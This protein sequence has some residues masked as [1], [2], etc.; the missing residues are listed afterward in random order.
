M[1]RKTYIRLLIALL[2]MSVQMISAKVTG[3]DKAVEPITW[4]TY[5]N[6]YYGF[7]VRVPST[8]L[9]QGENLFQDAQQFVYKDGLAVMEVSGG[10]NDGILLNQGIEQSFYAEMEKAKRDKGFIRQS[11]VLNTHYV[12]FYNRGDS[13]YYVSCRWNDNMQVRISLRYPT[14][15]DKK[16]HHFVEP[17]VYQR[18]NV[19]TEEQRLLASKVAT[20][21]IDAPDTSYDDSNTELAGDLAANATLPTGNADTS[22]N[23]D[24]STTVPSGYAAGDKT[25]VHQSQPQTVEIPTY[26]G[27]DVITVVYPDGTTMPDNPTVPGGLPTGDNSYTPTD[28]TGGNVSSLPS[29]DEYAPVNLPHIAMSDNQD[30]AISP[31][32]LETIANSPSPFDNIG[33]ANTA[34]SRNSANATVVTTTR[35]NESE[36]LVAFRTYHDSRYGFNVRYPASMQA[37]Q[38]LNAAG[39]K[40]IGGPDGKAYMTIMGRKTKPAESLRE[41]YNSILSVLRGLN[42]VKVLSSE[43][44]D[45]DY[46]IVYRNHYAK[47]IQYQREIRLGTT[48][49][50]VSLIINAGNET[51]YKDAI[52]A[53]YE[54][55][56]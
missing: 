14:K 15:Q 19:A 49:V 34:D 5:V 38:G 3:Y 10:Y 18:W 33:Q 40:Y 36:A 12:L 43:I 26:N 37:S 20:G 25:P 30:A 21:V 35:R 23:I 54:P 6:S 8:F 44:H 7:T 46:L 1:K 55:V 24:T 31:S 28:N 47:K 29:V 53:M 42:Y 11:Q 39:E 2:V 50:D 9:P 27:D 52:K 13:S 45:N 56:N 17:C 48:Q 16:L 41:H 51:H 22:D 4:Y 32:Q